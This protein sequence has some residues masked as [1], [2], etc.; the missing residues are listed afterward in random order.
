MTHR[1]RGIQGQKTKSKI[2]WNAKSNSVFR[3]AG[4]FAD[5]DT[6]AFIK[7]SCCLNCYVL[8]HV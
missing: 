3:L 1:V 6:P 8:L 4:L 7:T 2:F 5:A